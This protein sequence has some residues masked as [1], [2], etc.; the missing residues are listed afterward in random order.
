MYLAQSNKA[1]ARNA[2]PHTER[3]S[4]KG[5]RDDHPHAQAYHHDYLEREFGTGYGRSSG[6]ASRDAYSGSK[7]YLN[8]TTHSLFR[9]S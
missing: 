5:A 4:A 8:N 7:R 3:R 1:S 9:F 2:Y 6:Y